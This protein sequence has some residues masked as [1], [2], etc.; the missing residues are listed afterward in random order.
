MKYLL[1]IFIFLTLTWNDN[2]GIETD[3]LV[4]RSDNPNNPRFNVIMILPA[5][6]NRFIDTNL[7]KNKKYCYVVEA[8][9]KPLN[10]GEYSNVYCQN[11]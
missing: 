1:S 3:Y 4:L 11:T 5:N 7:K 9:N 10:L 8:I 2:S 6:S